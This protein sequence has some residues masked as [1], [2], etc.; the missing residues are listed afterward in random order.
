MV[1][2][3]DYRDNEFETFDDAD[4]IGIDPDN[5]GV[6]RV[7]KGAKVVALIPIDQIDVIQIESDGADDDPTP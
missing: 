1:V 3:V 4:G 6:I 5:N 7:T 2:R